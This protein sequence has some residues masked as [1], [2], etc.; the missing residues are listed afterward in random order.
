MAKVYA[1]AKDLDQAI[2]SQQRA[3]DVFNNLEKYQDTDYLAQIVMTLSD[4]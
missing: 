1:K 3:F 4:Y 2:E